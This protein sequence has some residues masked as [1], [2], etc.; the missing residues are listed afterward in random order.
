MSCGA[1]RGGEEASFLRFFFFF[2]PPPLQCGPRTAVRRAS[3]TLPPS[4]ILFVLLLTGIGST[5]AVS[6]T[7][8][9][10]GGVAGAAVPVGLTPASAA[11]TL[12]LPF[13]D[14]NY[15]IVCVSTIYIT[16]QNS[17][18][19][20]LP[21]PTITG[22]S[23]SGTFTID[24]TIQ[25][26]DNIRASVS[27]FTIPATFL[28]PS[29]VTVSIFGGVTNG[30]EDARLAAVCELWDAIWIGNVQAVTSNANSDPPPAT[31]TTAGQTVHIAGSGLAA[32][33]GSK[34][35]PFVLSAAQ[36]A[37]GFS[38]PSGSFGGVTGDPGVLELMMA[39]SSTISPT[40]GSTVDPAQFA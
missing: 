9:A 23:L 31:R 16:N 40:S 25:D 7:S 4:S 15:Y 8:S 22:T 24:T 17:K 3:H 13:A 35:N 34:V 29:P 39:A 20:A 38:S 10:V 37:Q 32:N 26:G 6:P 30:S 27:H 18:T 19:V 1:A 33:S 21:A 5:L 11:F 14:A 2:P 36:T 12:S 28:G